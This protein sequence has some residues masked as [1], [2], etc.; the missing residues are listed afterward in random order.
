MAPWRESVVSI[1][2]QSQE[3]SLNVRKTESRSVTGE[4]LEK[5]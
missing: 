2:F 4:A 3:H 1:K 5:E